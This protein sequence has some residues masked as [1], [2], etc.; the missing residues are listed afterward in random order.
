MKIIIGIQSRI[1][2]S[3]LPAKALLRL[4]DTTVLGMIIQRALTT[5][6]PVYLLTSEHEYDHLLENEAYKNGVNGVIKGPLNNVL[7]R[8]I[9]LAEEYKPD[10]VIRV[11]ADN[12]LTE[13]RYIK[14]LVDYMLE[15][16]IEYSWIN[17]R[18]CPD[19]TNLEVF[20]PNLIF[21][22]SSVDHSQYNKENVTPWMKSVSGSKKDACNSSIQ[23][24]LPI[25]GQHYHFGIDTLDDYCKVSTLIDHLIQKGFDWR[26]QD[27][28]KESVLEVTGL[29]SN[30]PSGRRHAI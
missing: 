23:S 25:N 27:F 2:S 20:A 11:T 7:A 5:T 6:F 22:S 10:I 30:F 13:F 3:R 16:G 29:N 14:P 17:P 12:P 1:S 19:G 9:N 8:F 26:H 18:L 21:R 4:A 24:I 15:N 28:V